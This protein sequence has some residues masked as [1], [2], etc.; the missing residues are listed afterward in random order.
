MAS[1]R[2]FITTTWT[3]YFIILHTIHSPDSMIM[4]LLSFFVLCLAACSE[5]NILLQSEQSINLVIHLYHHKYSMLLVFYQ[6]HKVHIC[7]IPLVVIV[8][9]YLNLHILGKFSIDYLLF[10]WSFISSYYLFILDIL[11]ISSVIE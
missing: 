11:F 7:L 3:F 5:Q 9:I 1:I 8:L 4:K 2:Y 10:F 6:N